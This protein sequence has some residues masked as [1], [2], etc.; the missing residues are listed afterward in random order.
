MRP[1]TVLLLTTSRP[2]R[3][4]I[5]S[6][7]EAIGQVTEAQPARTSEHIQRGAP[8]N[9]IDTVVTPDSPVPTPGGRAAAEPAPTHEMTRTSGLRPRP[10]VH[11]LGIMAVIAL[12]AAAL[13]TRLATATPLPPID[14]TNDHVHCSSMIA[15]IQISPP[16]GA[17]SPAVTKFAIRGTLLGC[18]DTD[19]PSV[20]VLSGKVAG[21]LTTTAPISVDALTGQTTPVTGTIM[22]TWKTPVASPKLVSPTTTLSPTA[23]DTKSTLNP[24]TEGLPVFGDSS[25]DTFIAFTIGSPDAITSIG[26][27]TGGDRGISSTIIAVTS[28]S[29]EALGVE[30]ESTGKLPSLQLGIGAAQLG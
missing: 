13:G 7:H 6:H 18:L 8:M 10:G 25:G 1:I 24:N 9:T 2:P 15:G 29:L 20:T 5:A 28:P 30:L 16:F 21:T 27:F 14:A 11:R 26:S 19:N 12:V 17:A 3:R 4:T 23:L 22:I